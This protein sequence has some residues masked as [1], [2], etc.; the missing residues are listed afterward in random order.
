MY[1]KKYIWLNNVNYIFLLP[2]LI[3]YLSNVFIIKLYT[4]HMITIITNKEF[5]LFIIFIKMVFFV[6]FHL[7][8]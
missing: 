2:Y 4:A 5:V 1:I 7:K 6:Y 8:Y 3:S